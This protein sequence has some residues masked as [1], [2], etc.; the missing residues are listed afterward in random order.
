V[1]HDSIEVTSHEPSLV[2][3]F[4]KLCPGVAT[5]LLFYRSEKWMRSDVVAYNAIHR[6][7]HAK[8]R[9]VHLNPTQ[10][11]DEIVNGVREQGIQIHAWDVNSREHLRHVLDFE[12]KRICTDNL[13]EIQ[14]FIRMG[15]L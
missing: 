4:S 15:K 6:A 14:Q 2:F 13:G 11:S 5:N 1:F 8:A 3:E 7:K 10:L 12:I 9:A